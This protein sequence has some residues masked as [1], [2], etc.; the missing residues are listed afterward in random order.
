M[1]IRPWYVWLYVFLFAERRLGRPVI[2]PRV[3]RWMRPPFPPERHQW[4]R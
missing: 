2:T 4:P 3:A 1:K